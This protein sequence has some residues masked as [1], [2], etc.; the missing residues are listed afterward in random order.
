MKRK[1]KE[2]WVFLFSFPGSE[3][4][5]ENSEQAWMVP[6]FFVDCSQLHVCKFTF[7]PPNS[8]GATL[9][10][11]I[12]LT[13][14]NS[15]L[16]WS[17][18]FR[19]PSPCSYTSERR[20]Q[21]HQT[22]RLHCWVTAASLGLSL[23]QRKKKGRSYHLWSLSLTL[24]LCLIEAP[25]HLM[26]GCGSWGMSPL[27]PCLYRLRIKAIFLFPPNS[28]SVIFHSSLVGREGWDFGQ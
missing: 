4:D 24:S 26:E 22:A 23:K 25:R 17:S 21:S 9:R 6:S 19:R 5:K 8:A 11:Y 12:P 18:P 1:E 13:L 2:E 20:L 7:L 15:P 27:C 16:I 28:V 10:T 3:E 14:L